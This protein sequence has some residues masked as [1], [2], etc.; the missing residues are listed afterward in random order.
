MKE[1][2]WIDREECV[3]IHELLLSRHGGAEGVRDEKL[4]EAALARPRER[5]AAGEVKLA[6]LAACYGFEIASTQP[7]INGNAATGFL[8]AATFLRIN[9]L[10]FTGKEAP[11]TEDTLAVARGTCSEAF[12]AHFF[13][14]NTRAS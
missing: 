5:F 1:P 11:V 13:R 6:N 12:Y 7:F 3:I 10:V 14:C 4:L 2:R 9:G 8:V